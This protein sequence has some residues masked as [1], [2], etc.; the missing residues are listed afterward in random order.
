MSE[1][2]IVEILDWDEMQIVEI[3]IRLRFNIGASKGGYFMITEILEITAELLF[4][5]G[6]R[7]PLNSKKADK[8]IEELRRYQWFTELYEDKRYHHLFFGNRRVRKV[9]RSKYR[10]KRLINNTSAQGTFI[11][12]LDKQNQK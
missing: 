12:L 1:E 11:S 9:L 10:T 8:H 7:D 5:G 6:R 2:V 4:N 3:R